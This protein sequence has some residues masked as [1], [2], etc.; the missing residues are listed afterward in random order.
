M[1]R[2]TG[3]F[4]DA[5]AAGPVLLDGGLSNVLLDLGADLSGGMWTGRVLREEPGT[6]R[7][8]HAA[9]A[10]AGARVLTTSSYQ[11]GS[12]VP[13]GAGPDRAELEALWER[14]VALAAEVAASA[15]RATWVAASVGPYGAVL[16]D[17]SEYRGRYGLSRAELADWHRPRLRALAAAGAD[18]LAVETVPDLVEAEALTGL[19]SEVGVPA[20]LTF[21]LSEDGRHTAAGQPLADAFALAGAS[22]GVVATGVNCCAPEQVATA[23]EIAAGVT[24]KPLVAYPNDGS[25]WEAATSTWHAP[26]GA[27]GSP[28]ELSWP[29]DTWRA[30]G[31][32]L[33]GGCCRVGPAGIA[34]LAGPLGTPSASAR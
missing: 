28:A 14:S 2:A 31:A 26:E 9:Y 11:V 21:T 34:S 5:L 33:I 6:I 24:D 22:A 1:S 20:W 3:S 32:R 7:A 17:G 15:G 13:V 29:L 23:L 10:A 4:A 19:L 30:L 16:G 18:V 12:G 8:A 25:R 27:P